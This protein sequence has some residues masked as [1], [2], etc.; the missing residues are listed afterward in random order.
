M[1]KLFFLLTSLLLINSVIAQSTP[2]APTVTGVSVGYGTG[3]V[4]VNFT[5]G[6]GTAT[7][8]AVISKPARRGGEFVGQGSP[9]HVTGLVPGQAYTFT[10]VAING[11]G[12]SAASAASASVVPRRPWIIGIEND[13]YGASVDPM[14]GLGVNPD[15]SEFDLDTHE[16]IILATIPNTPVKYFGF[17]TYIVTTNPE[18]SEL[19]TM[20]FTVVDLGS[21]K[22]RDFNGIARS[23]LNSA[24]PIYYVTTNGTIVSW[25]GSDQLNPYTSEALATGEQ[26]EIQP[27]P[28]EF[29]ESFVAGGAGAGTFPLNATIS[30]DQTISAGS[31]ATLE[32]D[33]FGYMDQYNSPFT[34]GKVTITYADS[35]GGTYTTEGAYAT[36][37]FTIQ[38][39]PLSP[40]THVFTILYVQNQYQFTSG[41]A[42]GAGSATVVVTASTTATISGTASVCQN[43][44][45]PSIT[46]TGSNGTM[47]YTFT[48]DINGGS[49]QTIT[50]AAG[51]PTV[52]ITTPTATPGT[53][54]YNL[55]SMADAN[56][57]RAQSGQATVTVS[58]P[59][60]VNQPSDLVVCAGQSLTIKYTGSVPGTTFSWTNSNTSTGLS[61][62]GKGTTTFTAT[63]TTHAPI[64]ATVLVTPL[65]VGGFA[66]ITNQLTNDVSVINTAINAV[67]ATIPVGTD[68]VGVSVSP[69]GSKVYVTNA[70]SQTVSVIS[71]AGNTVIATIGVGQSPIG[72]SVS[73]DGSKVYVANLASSDLSVIDAN[74][75]TVIAT[76]VVGQ[77]P[78]GVAASPDGSRVY[79][80]NASGDVS[81]INTAS[82]T[83]IATIPV[84][85]SPFGI[86]VTP[87]G[88]KVYVTN[89][90][91]SDVSVIDA[92]TNTVIATIPMG[93]TP[94]AVSAS[95]DGSRVYVTS[96]S[97]GNVSV[98]NT[99]SNTVIATIAVGSYPYGISVSPD[100]GKV[101]VATDGSDA[102]Y[103]IDANTNTVIN[104]IRTGGSPAG[105]G[106]FIIPG[107][108]C[109][110]MAKR[111]TITVNPSPVITCPGDQT[112]TTTGNTNSAVVNYTAASPTTPAPAITYAFTGATTGTGAGIG[113]GSTF[114]KG[115]TSVTITAMDSCGSTNCTF[116]V[117]VN[118]SQTTVDHEAPVAI[119][120]ANVVAFNDPGKKG[121]VVN[122]SSTGTVGFY[123]LADDIS[124]KNLNS[125][126]FSTVSSTPIIVNDPNYITSGSQNI[127]G[128][129]MD[130]TTGTTYAILTPK[131]NFPA[132]RFLAKINL[133]TGAAS[134]IGNLHHA[135]ASIAFS[136]DGTLY[137][138]AGNADPCYN[139]LFSINKSTAVATSVMNVTIYGN[140]IGRALAYN[141]DDGMLYFWTYQ[142]MSKIDLVT[143]SQ[144]LVTSDVGQGI[145]EPSAATYLG[146]GKF[147]LMSKTPDMGVFVADVN[148]SHARV[149]TTD[150]F[151]RGV[152]KAVYGQIAGTDNS[153]EVVNIQTKGLPSGS[154]FPLGTTTNTFV[155][156]DASGNAVTCSFDV[157][158]NDNE[159]P[160]VVCHENII[161]PNDPGVAGAVV[162]Y[163]LANFSSDSLY[164][165]WGGL[166]RKFNGHDGSIISDVP[167]TVSGLSGELIVQSIAL[168][169]TSGQVYIGLVVDA[170]FSNVLLATVDLSSGAAVIR[171]NTNHPIVA[172][173][174]DQNGRLFATA[175]NS[176]VCPDCLYQI[177]K[178]TAQATGVMNL[179]NPGGTALAF[180]FD[181]HMLYCGNNLILSKIDLNTFTETIVNNSVNLRSIQGNNLGHIIY[182]GDGKFYVTDMRDGNFGII[183]VNGMG[184]Q[185]LPGLSFP[186]PQGFLLAGFASVGAS[187]NSGHYTVTQT[188][189]L[190]SGSLFPIGTTTNTFE[191]TDPSI[192]FQIVHSLLR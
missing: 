122:Y 24:S 182:I 179:I 176:D 106:N 73:P 89:V 26:Y 158:V 53:Y 58:A 184:V 22:E 181:D 152:F 34:P 123:S 29:R 35:Q 153:S 68:P 81:V 80:T 98:I 30:G 17:D 42:G 128:L 59:P 102:V 94:F 72:I 162:N 161:Q 44:T 120:P 60:D 166:L 46:F 138:I 78:F 65:A 105:L 55:V 112:A 103:V 187:D 171:G 137:G 6:S 97:S 178:R 188:R 147:H 3:D 16:L 141:Y 110:G 133:A 130:P 48:Y 82:N 19:L 52:T 62:S 63:N 186:H 170:D 36:S 86:S 115:I 85:A 131:R 27:T 28:A 125:F 100:G 144:T 50:T 20:Y 76:V 23:A 165:I 77:N 54:T 99:A 183:D 45:A 43:A 121:A 5:P 32:F 12:R 84:G 189:G 191:I 108:V 101:Y 40:G 132:D 4:F 192:M 64:T 168:D 139:C 135:I 95:P 11:S 173:A 38:T 74:S 8:Y 109:T 92:N 91:S 31:T 57:S 71:T 37:P 70:G 177:D 61:S 129:S 56:G 164:A 157:T 96:Q 154:L 87:D 79:V 143:F 41:G 140:G 148:G 126:D 18:T 151:S 172:M 15:G 116:T 174:F 111:F 69:D 21:F 93:L 146:A 156:A 33:I 159:P 118:E 7:S 163:G 47:P 185:G 104:T 90:N 167:V 136:A 14:T 49:P 83:V 113:S 107:A 117:T 25:D 150:Q 169:P 175:D 88:S 2:G 142:S 190:P 124:I 1:R 119:C 145:T 180:N 39:G 134:I 160:V 66:Y 127:N 114:N 149:G 75:N 51:D 9:V 13:F 10:V 67:V 155:T